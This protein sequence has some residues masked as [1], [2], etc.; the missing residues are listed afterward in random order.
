[1][2]ALAYEDLDFHTRAALRG[3]PY[4]ETSDSANLPI[5]WSNAF[6]DPKMM[7]LP[8]ATLWVLIFFAPVCAIDPNQPATNLLRTH[9]TVDEG[10]P[11]PVVDHIQ[12]TG[13]GFLWLITNGSNLSRFDGKNFYNLTKPRPRL[14]ALAPDGDLWLATLDEELIRMPAANFNQFTLSGFT[15][16]RPDPAKAIQIL[17]LRFTRNGVLWVGTSDGLFRFDGNQFVAVGPRVSTARIQES[18]DGNLLVLN[19]QGLMELRDSEIVSQTQLAGR[20]GVAHNEIF[21]VLKDRHGN[22]WYCTGRGVMR[23]HNRRI[24][25]L[26]SHGPIGHGATIAYGDSQGNVWIGK[27][28]GL[29]RGTSAGLEVVDDKI[30]VRSI[31]S[32]RDGSLWVG[33]NGDGMYRFKDRVIRMFTTKDGL[34]NDSLMTALVTHDGAVWTG[35]NCGGITRFD[36]TRFQTYNEKHGLLNSCVWALAEDL[37]RDLWIGTWGGGVFRFQNGTFTQF[38]KGH[39]LEDDRV[40][41]IAAARDGSVWF[42]TRGGGLTRLKQ[43]QFRTYTTADGLSANVILK[44][45]ED[46]AGNIWVGSRHGLDRLV[47]DRFENFTDVPKTFAVPIGEDRD[48]G[49][50][51]VTEV[52]EEAS[53]RR[54]HKARVDTMTYLAA[55]DM[56]ETEQGEIWFGGSPLSRVQPGS[57]ARSHDEPPDFEEITTADGLLDRDTSGP[58]TLALTRDGKLYAATR[59]GLAML[60]LGRMAVTS[61]KPSIYLRDITIGRNTQKAGREVILPP[62]TNHF[63][64]HFAAVE[65]SAPEKI[66]MQYR[67]DGVDSEWLDAPANPVAIY[68]RIP[69]GT[70]ALRIRACN[71]NGIWDREGVIFSVTQQPYFY[72]TRWF[73]AAM[74]AFGIVLVVL[75]HRLRVAQISRVLSARFDERLAERT[76]VAREIHDT[77]LQTVQGSKLVADHALKNSADHNL[78]VRALEQLSTWL[79]QATEEGRTALLSL[80]ATATEKSDLAEALGHAIDECGRESGAKVSFAVH[81]DVREVHPIVRDELYRIGYEAIRNACRHSRGDRLEVTLEYAHDLTLRVSDNGI[82]IEAE[83]IEK[84]KD[85]HFGLRG[86]R[87]RA[88]RTGSKFTL[89]SL[90]ESGTVV[91]AVVPGRIAFRRT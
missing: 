86:M 69:V 34:P 68:S 12:Q 48:G 90:P 17:C 78:A 41:T 88:E 56:V 63:Q 89:V 43:G 67:L 28:A 59:Q 46:R 21:D 61:T 22:T 71:R 29:F 15:S 77:F 51:M 14:I 38:S 83:V 42:G 23:E 80:R 60:D 8:I 9:F 40:T 26:G 79:A 16:Y 31:F 55:Y 57:F 36:G 37:N 75:V 85:G 50:F 73:I 54:R 39:G 44:V 1:M 70:H 47:G 3:R 2:A 19:A 7:R 30:K 74:F 87:E 6:D 52:D 45:L 13:D 72:Q 53:T 35:A 49:F 5:R 10:M 18:P 11:G 4:N 84:G 76:R 33:T 24:E 58:G 66:R 27:E 32:D 81:G 65:I 64:I 91:T 20:L 82:G 62:G 25:Q